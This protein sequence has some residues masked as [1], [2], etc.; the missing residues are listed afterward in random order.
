MDGAGV[1]N[2][3]SPPGSTVGNDNGQNTT[4]DISPST[5]EVTAFVGVGEIKLSF[6]FNLQATGGAWSDGFTVTLPD[7]LTILR[8]E[9][10]EVIAA[11]GRCSGAPVIDGQ[12]LT[13]G[14]D[15]VTLYGCIEGAT[16]FSVYVELFD[17]VANPAT[18]AWGAYDDGWGDYYYDVGIANAG[19][20]LVVNS[21]TYQTSTITVWDVHNVTQNSTVMQ[22]Q[23]ILG[24]AD[25]L[26][27]TTY[28]GVTDKGWAHFDGIKI[29]VINK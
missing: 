21:L 5:C 1:W 9:D 27:G 4:N 10:N 7:E 29:K 8:G 3:G 17:P 23:T 6:D 13:W 26:T 12:T 15:D 24:G 20:E 2:P 28:G 16:T 19:G 18:I 14:N 11:T 22:N 25:Q